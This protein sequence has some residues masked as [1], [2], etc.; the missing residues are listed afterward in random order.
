M[1]L[2]SIV[3][4]FDNP[5]RSQCSRAGHSALLGE[6]GICIKEPTVQTEEADR[7]GE[8]QEH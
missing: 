7:V 3:Q 8:E 1:L 2:F 6:D 5:K 4:M